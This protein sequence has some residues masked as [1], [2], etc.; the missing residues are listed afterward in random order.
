M[1]YNYI[2]IQGFDLYLNAG[3]AVTFAVSDDL[4]QNESVQLLCDGQINWEF[5]NE[6]TNMW[7]I[8]IESAWK[9]QAQNY[10]A[11]KF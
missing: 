10:I 11:K 1:K 6:F 2:I 3:H 8:K 4:N 5:S 9:F 7:V